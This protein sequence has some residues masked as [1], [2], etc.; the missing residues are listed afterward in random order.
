[1]A[2]NRIFQDKTSFEVSNRRDL[3]LIAHYFNQKALE[4]DVNG[5]NSLS[6][7]SS[8]EAG[9]DS[10]RTYF[11]MTEEEAKQLSA[12]LISKGY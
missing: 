2:N 10:Q 5:D 7:N 12:F 8:E 4:F 6:I 1:M 11:T 3:I 9:W